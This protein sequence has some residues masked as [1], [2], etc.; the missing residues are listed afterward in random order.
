MEAYLA[1]ASSTEV[2]YI[3]VTGI[4]AAEL[5]GA[6]G[7]SGSPP[8]PGALGQKI[9][10]NPSKKVALKLP[11]GLSGTDMS[12]C[13]N[14][15]ENLVSVENLPSGVTNMRCCFY[16]CQGLTTVP[17]MLTGS[18][19]LNMELCF[20]NCKNL[21]TAP[22]IP[23]GVFAIGKCFQN[24]KKLQSVKVHCSYG[25][26]FSGAFSGCDALPNG[27]IKVPPA[28][29]G[30]YKANAAAMGTTPAKFSAIP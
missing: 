4:S 30:I 19:S 27:G 11:S 25:S 28:Q 23:A 24:C 29:L 16:D 18:G 5:K 2:N 13:F 15:C 9:K 3:E 7:A 21:V 22:D 1:N 20:Y 26:N 12:Y 10:N 14:L 8:N 17:A 6:P